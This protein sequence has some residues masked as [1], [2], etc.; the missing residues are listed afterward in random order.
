MGKLDLL[1]KACILLAVLAAM[2]IAAP[3][4]T[5]TSF[6]FD[7]TDGEFP[8]GVLVQATDGNL[9]GTTRNGGVYN[10]GAVFQMNLSGS[11]TTLHSFGPGGD[12]R[13]PQA[14]L[15]QATDGNFY[16][17]TSDGGDYSRGNIFQ[18][19]PAGAQTTLYSFCSQT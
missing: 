18:I 16:G 2:A 6:S 10:S 5:F 13:Y 7:G 12:G 3:A 11:V 19:T 17:T 9:Y 14:G 4:Q 1:K 8:Q 15:V